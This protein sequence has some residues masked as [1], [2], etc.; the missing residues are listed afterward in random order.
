MRASAK[1]K[2]ILFTILLL[3]FGLFI[4][5]KYYFLDKKNEVGQLKVISSPESS[6]FIDNI[7]VGKT[8]FEGKYKV[9]E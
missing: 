5:G 2:L 7:A 9:G 6:L 3:L 4:A 8:P 1:G